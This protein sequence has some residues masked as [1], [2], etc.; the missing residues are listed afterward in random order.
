MKYGKQWIGCRAKLVKEY[1][2]VKE[3]CVVEL[4]SLSPFVG[5]YKVT[6]LTGERTGESALIHSTAMDEVATDAL[7]TK[8]EPKAEE[9]KAPEV[10][11]RALKISRV[12]DLPSSTRDIVVERNRKINLRNETFATE[13]NAFVDDV[14]K[15]TVFLVGVRSI[16]CELFGNNAGLG[17]SKLRV[18]I[19]IQRLLNAASAQSHL[20]DEQRIICQRSKLEFEP[21]KSNAYVGYFFVAPVNNGDIERWTQ[22]QPDNF[23]VI[24]DNPTTDANDDETV[25]VAIVS[26]Y[27]KEFEKFTGI[28]KKHF[29]LMLDKYERLTSDRE[30]EK[31][32]KDI[33]YLETGD[34]VPQ[35]LIDTLKLKA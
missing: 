14:N 5:L 7:T 10:P 12:Q 25:A 2:N 6:V 33:W 29:R 17:V 3:G 16:G 1:D 31:A 19:D 21:V 4:K 30:V 35:N 9:K 15:N 13:L 32:I 20:T 18:G 26:E 28:C 23:D 22:S 27:E 8:V 11:A 24:I 34:V